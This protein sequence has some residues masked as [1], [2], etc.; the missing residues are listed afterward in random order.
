MKNV[1]NTIYLNIAEI[2]LR[3]R[4]IS[5]AKKQINFLAYHGLDQQ[6]VKLLEGFVEVQKP[7]TT[8]LTID[9][10][11]DVPTFRRYTDDSTAQNYILFS[12]AGIN[13]I[14]SFQHISYSQFMNLLLINLQQLLAKNK[15]FLLHAAANNVLGNAYIYTGSSGAGKSTAMTYLHKKY[16]SLADDSVII[17]KEKGSFYFYQ[18]PF[19][20]KNSWVIKIKGSHKI[21]GV[22]FLRK[23]SYFKAERI[24]NKNYIFSRLAKQLWTDTMSLRQQMKYFMEFVQSFNEFY[25][26][27]FAKDEEK[28]TEVI[29]SFLSRKT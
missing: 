27:S 5:S 28:F 14:K 15:G 22:F 21:G 16:P 10:F 11:K 13:S 1:N 4:F 9:L 7:K 8:F 26:L 6:I 25:L 29:E 19:I 24:T 12:E 23:S 2:R 17:K 20:E 3:I 18:T